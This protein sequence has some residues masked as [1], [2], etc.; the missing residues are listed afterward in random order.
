M[1]GQL[2]GVR[3]S[4][5]RERQD[6]QPFSIAD[7]RSCLCSK[8]A[9]ALRIV[10]NDGERLDTTACVGA[11]TAKL[12]PGA[13]M[14]WINC[15]SCHHVR[16]PYVAGPDANPVSLLRGECLSRDPVAPE[17]RAQYIKA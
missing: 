8:M 15:A 14:A 11:T 17:R 10:P 2:D 13:E 3:L 1:R 16:F 9:S 6:N 5:R 12:D 7:R 4:Q